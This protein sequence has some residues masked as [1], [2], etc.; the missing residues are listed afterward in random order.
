MEADNQSDRLILEIFNYIQLRFLV[1]ALLCNFSFCSPCSSFIGWWELFSK[2]TSTDREIQR[3]HME[4]LNQSD[5]LD[6]LGKRKNWTSSPIST[7]WKCSSYQVLRVSEML[8][9]FLL[10]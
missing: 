9:V 7:P 10:N 5:G 8:Q 6:N 1:E 2:G 3:T 4:L